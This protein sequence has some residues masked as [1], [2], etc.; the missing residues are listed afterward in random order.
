MFYLPHI[1]S[2][3]GPVVEARL[4]STGPG[5]SPLLQK[6]KEKERKVLQ[7]PKSLGSKVLTHL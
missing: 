7:R 2:Q 6:K 3:R 4:A 5:F 1:W